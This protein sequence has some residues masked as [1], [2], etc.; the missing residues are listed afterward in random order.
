MVLGAGSVTA[1]TGMPVGAEVGATGVGAGVVPGVGAA[2][3]GVA[4][5]VDAGVFIDAPSA[6]VILPCCVVVPATTGTG[7]VLAPV[8]ANSLNPPGAASVEEEPLC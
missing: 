8:G 5:A 3:S 7:V 1:C 2:G 6:L 4:V